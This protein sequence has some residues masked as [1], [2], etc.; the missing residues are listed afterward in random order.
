MVEWRCKTTHYQR[1]RYYC[2]GCR[3]R[4]R[5]PL[6][7]GVGSSNFGPKLQAAV[8]LITGRYHLSKRE[9]SSLF[10]EICGVHLCSGVISKIES[11][12]SSAL[13]EPYEEIKESI[14]SGSS[15]TYIDETGWRH[16]AQNHYVWQ[17]S[18]SV[19]T[20]TTIEDSRCRM[21]RDELIGTEFS[22]PV[23]TDRYVGYADLSGPHQHCLA[24]IARDFRKFSECEGIAGCVGKELLEHL[25]GAFKTWKTFRKES[26]SLDKLRNRT[27]YRS[28]RIESLLYEG[29]YSGTLKFQRFCKGLLNR[30]ENLWM[31][32]KIEGMHPTN[33]QAERELR[34]L[35]LWRKRSNG[36]RGT[37]GLY[38]VSRISSVVQTLQRQKRSVF[39][40]LSDVLYSRA[41]SLACPKVLS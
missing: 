41:Q 11:R 26:L 36:T 37:P 21:A 2:S 9:A 38:Y 17:A 34:P 29:M 40:F 13:K 33:N 22:H 7:K 24:H 4:F 6:P 15:T 32:L 10:R 30:F 27:R 23:V 8:G 19:A 18:N 1:D 12:I 5:A 28:K 25:R 31:Y 3:R 16:A 35:V 14:R 39:D 20:L